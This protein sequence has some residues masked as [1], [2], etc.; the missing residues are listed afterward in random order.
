MP[1]A[2]MAVAPSQAI[3]P[4]L[5]VTIITPM[6]APPEPIDANSTPEAIHAWR[7]REK[8]EI[9]RRI[10]ALSNSEAEHLCFVLQLIPRDE[11]FDQINVKGRLRRHIDAMRM[12]EEFTEIETAFHDLERDR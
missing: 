2:P 1:P 10:E 6:A 8:D 5:P 3:V 12:P 4:V 7:R 11:V 9:L